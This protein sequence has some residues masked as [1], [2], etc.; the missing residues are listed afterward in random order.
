MHQPPVN[1]SLRSARRFDELCDEFEKAYRDGRTPR[2]EDY[3]LRVDEADRPRFLRYL[4]PVE[5]ELLGGTGRIPEPEHYQQRLPDYAELIGEIYEQPRSDPEPERFDQAKR[6]DPGRFLRTA[7]PL[8]YAWCRQCG[9]STEDSYHIASAVLREFL[10]SPDSAPQDSILPEDAATQLRDRVVSSL[11]AH[12]AGVRE[13]GHESAL[14]RAEQLEEHVNQLAVAAVAAPVEEQSH[15]AS[16]DHHATPF[17]L[18]SECKDLVAHLQQEFGKTILT[19]SPEPVATGPNEL[20]VPTKVGGYRII[21]PIGRGGMGMV[22]RAEHTSLKRMVALKLLPDELAHN[23]E[24]V[25]R[26]RREMAAVGRLQHPNIVQAYDAGEDDGQCYLA[27]ELLDGV[28]LSELVRTC[29][30]LRVADACEVVR[31]A[32]IGLQHA[33]EHDFVHRDVKPSNLMITREGQ[34]KILD[35]G[36]SRL[37][38]ERLPEG[39]LTATGQ[40]LGTVHYMAPEQ[41]GDSHHADVRADLYSLG[42]TLFFLLTGSPPFGGA[43]RRN[44][45]QVI[46]AHASEPQPAL[47]PDI[48]P[49]PIE[50]FRLSQ[51]FGQLLA[52]HPDQRFSHP[53]E[54]IEELEPFCAD[55]NLAALVTR[56]TRSGGSASRSDESTASRRG[57]IT[58]EQ[59]PL[60]P[61]DSRLP[62][63]RRPKNL[64][65]WLLTGVAA[66][67]ACAVLLRIRTDAGTVE[68]EVASPDVEIIIDEERRSDFEIVTRNDRTFASLV[69][70]EGRHT[71]EVKHRGLTSYT[72]EFEIE[73]DETTVVKARFTPS[74]PGDPDIS[75][76]S[77]DP[78]AIP[79]KLRERLDSVAKQIE[80]G[81]D[82]DPEAE[83]NDRLRRELIDIHSRHDTSAAAVEAARLMPRVPWP[84]DALRREDIPEYERTVA[85]DGEAAEANSRIVAILGDSRLKHWGTVSSLDFSPDGALLASG[86]HDGAVRIWD[87]PSREQVEFIA[88]AD[89]VEGVAFHPDGTLIASC[90]RGGRIVVYNLQKRERL[91]EFQRDSSVSGLCWINEGETLLSSDTG[92]AICYWKLDSTDPEKSFRAGAAAV[93]AIAVD[94]NDRFLATGHRDAAIRLWD[95]QSGDLIREF[96]GDSGAVNSLTFAQDGNSLIS[97]GDDG[98]VRLWSTATGT[99]ARVLHQRR[100]NPLTMAVAADADGELVVFSDYMAAAVVHID[101]GERL[102]QLT[103]HRLTVHDV[104]FSPDGSLIA[105]ASRDCAI[106]LWNAQTGEDVTGIESHHSATTSVDVAPNGEA[107]AMMGAET[108]VT[109]R[110]LVGPN[111]SRSIPAKNSW[112]QAVRFSPDG[113]RLATIDEMGNLVVRDSNSLSE[114]FLWRLE[115]STTGSHRDIEFHPAGRLLAV[116]QPTEFVALCDATFP[117]NEQ[118]LIDW[119]EPHA[120]LGECDCLDVSADGRWIAAISLVNSKRTDVLILDTAS[121]K[122]EWGFSTTNRVTALAIAPDRPIVAIYGREARAIELV[123]FEAEATVVRR[124]ADHGKS[125]FLTFSP[126]GRRIASTGSNGA[127]RLWDGELTGP[128]DTIQIAPTQRSSVRELRFLA[129]QRHLLTANSNGTAYL[130]RL[131]DWTSADPESQRDGDEIR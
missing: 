121:K 52:K 104:A 55:S 108:R 107:L 25:L 99:Q 106:R 130:I 97:A 112:G 28:D 91:I 114:Q 49:H 87:V 68:I 19:E 44:M 76:D 77:R 45:V 84:A 61:T 72:D 56:V 103:G 67:I 8:V 129:D 6:T 90:D 98:A 66:F 24:A 29:G 62:A 131:E 18:E 43:D 48:L 50:Q 2:I 127:I 30:P 94:A 88:H 78:Y 110:Q 23:P 33:F 71:L 116:T 93:S 80:T 35:F 42:C 100:R 125:G 41:S 16:D 14:G 3:L 53:A 47:P 11:R 40:M 9:V 120:S 20:G 1:E 117:G 32:A 58:E 96:A 86:G 63:R 74:E 83:Q 101:S 113:Q 111:R 38:S 81:L 73:D 26:F 123:D 122:L 118:Q 39:E 60:F 31:Q 21:E 82:P 4:L 105:T 92:G 109:I 36:L 79:Q 46:Q 57:E 102:L 95:L 22:Y 64:I 5:L 115:V 10:K 59:P 27:M 34:V 128:P 70:R 7:G 37:G 15:D 13:L 54:L 51:I 17:T 126:D 85:A 75:R 119:L 12:V 89:A 69:V 124:E 65:P